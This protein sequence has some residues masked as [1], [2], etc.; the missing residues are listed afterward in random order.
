MLYLGGA[1]T[2][3]NGTESAMCRGVAVSADNGG[4]RKRKALFRA[5]DVHHALSDVI[6]IE[7]RYTK[8]L[9]VGLQ[10]FHLDAAFLILYWAIAVLCG[11]V[12]VGN[13]QRGIRPAHR[14]AGIAQALKGLWAGYLVHEMAVNVQEACA[15]LLDVDQVI[16]PNFVKQGAWLRHASFPSETV[17][18]RHI[19]SG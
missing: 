8:L 4:A 12:V 17:S 3:C 7:Q 2:E 1:N 9:A 5:D 10:G 14:S 15:V 6:N 18:P 11:N 19:R 13:R 16:I